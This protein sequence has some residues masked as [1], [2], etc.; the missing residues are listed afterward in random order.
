MS[1]GPHGYSRMR[2]G[3]R[4]QFRKRKD[5]SL[6]VSLIGHQIGRLRNP[7]V[8]VN[9]IIPRISQCIPPLSEKTIDHTNYPGFMHC[10]RTKC[11]SALKHLPPTRFF[12]GSFAGRC[13]LW[14]LVGCPSP[15]C[16][17][18]RYILIRRVRDG[19]NGCGW[20]FLCLPLPRFEL[21]TLP[22][23]KSW[24]WVSPRHSRSRLNSSVFFNTLGVSWQL[25]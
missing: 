22:A 4:M 3:V 11:R 15:L 8:P 17:I 9:K 23:V 5:T 18:G 13:S 19:R 20:C 24:V 12:L 21:L 6:L 14:T 7:L 1:V 10:L 16:P 25:G 2:L